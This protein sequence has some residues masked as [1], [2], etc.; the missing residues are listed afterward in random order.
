MGVIHH[1][2]VPRICVR[3][4]TPFTTKPSKVGR[5]CSKLCSRRAPFNEVHIEGDTALLTIENKSRGFIGQAVID[6]SD[7]PLVASLGRRWWARW[8]HSTKQFLAFANM[9]QDGK[10]SGVLL[11]RLIADAGL[12]QDVDHVNHV[13]LDCRRGNLRVCTRGENLQNR[14]GAMTTSKS[15][16]RNVRW[17]ASREQWAVEIKV[18]KRKR[19]IG[20]FDS[21]DAARYAAQ[22]ARKRYM[23]HSVE[24]EA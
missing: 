2:P 5:F 6:A 19:F 17:D 10:W 20:R 15:G 14:A 7:L 23:T 3:C 24:V 9:K 8:H 16:V 21:M 13:M 4:G 11:H 1:M 18:N 22:Q 12:G